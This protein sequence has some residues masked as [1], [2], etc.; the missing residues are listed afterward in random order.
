MEHEPHNHTH[1]HEH[2]HGAVEDYAARK[3]PEFVALDIGGDVGALIVH[4]DPEMHGIEIEISAAG[5][6]DRRTHKQVLER[7]VNERAAFTAVFDGLHAGRY[8]LWVDDQPRARDV[9][10]EGAQ[11][12]ELDWRSTVSA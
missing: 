5:E 10:I 7:K 11:I 3:H 6:D 9:A 8:T 1:D 12:A 2:P 4:T